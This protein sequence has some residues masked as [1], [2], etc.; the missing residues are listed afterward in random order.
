MIEENKKDLYG[1]RNKDY[2]EDYRDF[3]SLPSGSISGKEYESAI[4][5][6]TLPDSYLNKMQKKTGYR[7]TKWH[8]LISGEREKAGYHLFQAVFFGDEFSF[9]DSPSLKKY[10][11]LSF[12]TPSELIEKQQGMVGTCASLYYS[13]LIRSGI[14]LSTF[15]YYEV[16]SKYAEHL[17]DINSQ[18]AQDLWKE[19]ASNYGL[20]KKMRTGTEGEAVREFTLNRYIDL[21]MQDVVNKRLSFMDVGCGNGQLVEFALNHDI[22]AWGL[23]IGDA[24]NDSVRDRVYDGDIMEMDSLVGEAKYDCILANLLFEWTEDLEGVLTILRRHLTDKGV[25]YASFTP[26]EYQRAGSWIRKESGYYT[27][28]QKKCAKREKELVMINRCVGPLWF[29]PRSIAEI[30]KCISSADMAIKGIEDIY[31]NSYL[32]KR[33]IEEKEKEYPYLFRQNIIPLFTVFEIIP[34]EPSDRVYLVSPANLQKHKK[35]NV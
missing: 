14:E 18:T 8:L 26:P 29:Y 3:W 1:K 20:L 17:V 16:D 7:I 27:W 34:I 12:F 21:I 30:S 32:N 4:E 19:A 25:L 5:E 23:E 9:E 6:G 35:I 15:R 33:E 22:E 2:C 13:Y 24:V 11:E 31:V 10:D 28:E